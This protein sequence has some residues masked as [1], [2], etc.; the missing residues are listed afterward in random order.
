[1]RIKDIRLL[2]D[3]TQQSVAIEFATGEVRTLSAQQLYDATRTLGQ[4]ATETKTAAQRRAE[5]LLAMRRNR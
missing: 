5:E 4:G 3:G 1:M 2:D